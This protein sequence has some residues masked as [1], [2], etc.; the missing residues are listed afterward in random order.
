VA[1]ILI[2]QG[3][4]DQFLDTELKPELFKAAASKAG[5]ALTLRMQAGYDHSY[6]FIATYIEDHLRWHHRDLKQTA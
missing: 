5:Q 6:Y 3:T 4:A 1:H 2:D